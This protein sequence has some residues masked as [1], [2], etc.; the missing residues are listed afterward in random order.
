[1][2]WGTL[3]S[4]LILVAVWTMKK[5]WVWTPRY[6]NKNWQVHEERTHQ[7]K[8]FRWWFNQQR[9]HGWWTLVLVVGVPVAIASV[10]CQSPCEGWFQISENKLNMKFTAV[11]D[12]ANC[13]RMKKE[14]EP[15][16]NVFWKNGEVVFG[17]ATAHH[18]NLTWKL[19]QVRRSSVPDRHHRM[20]YPSSLAAELWHSLQPPA[21][22]KNQGT[23]FASIEMFHTHATF[24][25]RLFHIQHCHTQHFHTQLFHTI[26]L[27]PSP[28]SFMPSHLMFT[29]VLCWLEEVDIWGYPVLQFLI[30]Q[31]T[32]FYGMT[33][34]IPWFSCRKWLIS[35][36]LSENSVPLHPMV[37]DLYPY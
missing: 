19:K 29:S 9:L 18:R 4:N 37:N 34:K 35:M 5:I 13:A 6:T 30:P 22:K 33:V 14:L 20:S 27:P 1:M 26:C 16:W 12:C 7:T 15:P 17:L 11:S 21:T 8:C 36:G 25:T 28:I 31:T 2:E 3:F 32:N 24:H 10:S 23:S